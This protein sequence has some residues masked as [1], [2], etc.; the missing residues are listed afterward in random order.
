MIPSMGDAFSVQDRTVPAR[1]RKPGD[2]L[3]ILRQDHVTWSAKLRFHGE[4]FGW[5][6]QILRDGELMIARRSI[7]REE[8][9]TWAAT[10]S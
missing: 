3:W 8:A 10:T 6:A 5:E 1:W 4:S 9:V 7:P 2:P